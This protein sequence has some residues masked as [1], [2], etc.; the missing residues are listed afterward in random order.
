MNNT[1]KRVVI[2]RGLPGSGKSTL[3]Q[4]IAKE[5][6][7]ADQY[8]YNDHGE[9][10]YDFDQI[11]AAHKDCYERFQKSVDRECPSI[12]VSNTS[13]LNWEFEHYKEYAQE[14]GYLV[15][16]IIVENRH[17]GESIHDVPFSEIEA[18]EKRFKVQLL[19]KSRRLKT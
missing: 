9:Y 14:R 1:K 8:F 17:G 12:A 5:V 7:E 13:S 2:L 3:A 4:F 6:F 19:H 10:I 11:V 16:V 15:S 18:M